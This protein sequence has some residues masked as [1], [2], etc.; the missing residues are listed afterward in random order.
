MHIMLFMALGA[1]IG[2]FLNVVIYRLPLIMAGE[3]C[4]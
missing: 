1:I 3:K 2:S 4:R